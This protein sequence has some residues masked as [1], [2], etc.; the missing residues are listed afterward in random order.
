SAGPVNNLHA[1]LSSS[2]AGVSILAGA[3]DYPDLAPDAASL[4]AADYVIK[5][6]PSFVRGTHLE[7]AL[8]VTA[9]QGTTTFALRLP[10]GTPR[11]TV[12]YS[13]NFEGV[14]PGTLPAGW[15]AVHSAGTGGPGV[16]PWTTNATF[17]GSNAAF[18]PNDTSGTRF[19]RLI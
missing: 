8:A 19:E 2:T 17:T 11:A 12:I 18:H 14:A 13:E 5:L 16:V 10:T 1:T 4:P 6:A 15:Q 7:L 3:G 9:D